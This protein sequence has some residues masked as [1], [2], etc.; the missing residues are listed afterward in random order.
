MVL[1]R[2]QLDTPIQNRVLSMSASLESVPVK[3]IVL[4]METKGYRKVDKHKRRQRGGIT[5]PNM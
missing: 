4:E 5:A 2:S 3:S 1:H